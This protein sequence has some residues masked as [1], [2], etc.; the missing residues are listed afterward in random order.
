MTLDHLS[1][2]R[3]VAGLGTGYVEAEF[4]MTGIKISDENPPGDARRGADSDALVMDQRRTPSSA[5]ITNCAKRSVARPAAVPENHYRRRRTSDAAHREKHADVANITWRSQV[6]RFRAADLTAFDENRLK[7]PPL[8][9]D[10]AVKQGRARRGGDEQYPVEYRDK[11]KR[12]AQQRRLMTGIWDDRR[13]GTG[14]ADAA[15]WHA[16]TAR[17][18]PTAA[19]GDG[20]GR[21]QFG[22]FPLRTAKRLCG[23][24]PKQVLPHVG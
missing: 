15:D 20:L 8:L 19:S 4:R 10:E 11:P 22:I 13:T 17:D 1:G 23:Y 21:Y 7:E 18:R 3:A 2:G 16:G 24:S 6:G 14:L 5:S 12:D 9:R